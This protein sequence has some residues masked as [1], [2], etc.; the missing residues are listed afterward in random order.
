MAISDATLRLLAQT[1]LKKIVALTTIIEVNWL[2]LSY[3]F[4]D[5]SLVF[6]AHFLLIAHALTTASEF[7]LVEFIFKRYNSRDYWQISG[8]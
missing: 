4:G 5:N 2:N 8:L 1:D 3:F 7:L 6:V